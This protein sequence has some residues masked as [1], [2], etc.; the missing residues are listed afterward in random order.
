[1]SRT[2][3]RRRPDWRCLLLA[4]LFL[5]NLGAV[6]P[7]EDRVLDAHNRE[8]QAMGVAPLNWSEPLAAS[9]RAWAQHLATTGAFEHAP[10]DDV[11]PQG[12]NLWAGTRDSYAPEQMVAAWIAEKRNFTPGVF[13]NNSRTGKVEDVGHYTQ[14]IWR[15]TQSVGCARAR[16][17]SEDILVCRYGEAGNWIG[18]KPL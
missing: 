18:E 1:M 10:T 6:A 7:F 15:A 12:E 3:V 13:P 9:A 4:P 5:A 14:L 11:F 17:R 16:S 8:R 2:P